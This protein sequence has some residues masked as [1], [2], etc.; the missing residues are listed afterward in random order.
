[1]KEQKGFLEIDGQSIYYEY[2][3]K[4]FPNKAT[5]VLLHEG[6]GSVAQWKDIPQKIYQNTDYQVLVYDRSGYGIS[7]MPKA[8]Y[9]SDYL[10]Y[11]AQIM[12]PE[13]LNKLSIKKCALFGH[14]DG[15]SI[16]LLFAA[17]FPQRCSYVFSEAAHVVI[18]DISRQ[19]ISRVRK[20][21]TKKLQKP[22]QK[23]H[24]EKADWVFYHW[25]DTWLHKDNHQWNM[26]EELKNISCPLVAIQG[27][28]DEYGSPYQLALIQD[29]CTLAQTH[30]LKDCGHIP[31][32][33]AWQQVE[34]LL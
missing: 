19:G 4:N 29:N 9:P 8:D 1:M 2:F 26:I 20:I 28:K 11:E 6:L 17:Y 14:S 7:S 12:L 22:L 10:R 13:L 34:A 32:F 18:E 16:A 3:L 25:A 15:A 5:I 24:G 23:Y 21:Y 27:D 30:L 33:E 31:H